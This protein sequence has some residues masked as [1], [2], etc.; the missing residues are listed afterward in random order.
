MKAYLAVKYHSDHSNKTRIEGISAALAEYGIA[1]ICITRDLEKWGQV[2]FTYDVLMQKSFTEI[3][4][5]DLV[6]VD[7]TEKGV[8][9]GIEAGYAYARGIPVVTI[10]A[11][12]SD[13]SETLQ[14]V[15]RQVYFYDT[16]DELGPLIARSMMLCC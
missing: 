5:C 9:I 4:A 1:T 10:A 2:R 16:F 11:S 7:L 15:S 12:G 14:G 6:V 3:N 8:G 13:I